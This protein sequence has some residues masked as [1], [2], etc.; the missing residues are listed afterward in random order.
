GNKY[1]ASQDLLRET[2]QYDGSGGTVSIDSVYRTTGTKVKVE[3]PATFNFGMLFHKTLTNEV[4]TMDTWSFGFEYETSKWS[5]YRFNGLR[6]KV[7]D[8]W[9]FKLGGQF[10]PNASSASWIGRSTLRIGFNFGKDY[11]NADNKGLKV[12]TGSVGLGIPAGVRRDAKVNTALEFGKRGSNVNNVTESYF[13]FSV[14]LSL[15]D[16]WFVKRKYD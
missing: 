8:Y 4:G 15:S 16:L 1:N 6:D 5:Q 11:I 7:G 2:F 9:Q 10:I 12:F 3:T 14:G 13:R